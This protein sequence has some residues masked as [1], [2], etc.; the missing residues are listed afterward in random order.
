MLD[1]PGV[2]L[3]VSV[4]LKSSYSQEDGLEKAVGMFKKTLR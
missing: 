3:F 1:L 2:V 4:K